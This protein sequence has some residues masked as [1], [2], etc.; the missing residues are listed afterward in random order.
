MAGQAAYQNAPLDQD[1][2]RA[3]NFANRE[4]REKT[5]KSG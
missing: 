5:I 3:R 1:A 4:T 2:I